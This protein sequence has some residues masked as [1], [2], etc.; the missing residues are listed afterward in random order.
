MPRRDVGLLFTCEHGGNRVP[1]R[2]AGL[3]EKHR[4]LLDS[5]RGWDPGALTLARALSKAMAA[6]LVVS[7]TSRLLVDLNRSEHHRAVFSS[8]TLALP[9]AERRPPPGDCDLA[10][11][12]GHDPAG[13]RPHDA[14]VVSRAPV[15]AR[16]FAP[17]SG[18]CVR[19]A[20]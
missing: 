20:P 12:Q 8:I 6:P 10:G 15:T 16:T 13:R 18:W 11:R 7:T 2:W 9:D 17:T 1:R 3:F 19:V 14:A 5:H 4:T